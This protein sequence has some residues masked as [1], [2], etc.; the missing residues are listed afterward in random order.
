M[1]GPAKRVLPELTYRL[2]V[3]TF[4]QHGA[5]ELIYLGWALLPRIRHAKRVRRAGTTAER[6]V[7]GLD[8]PT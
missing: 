7:I 2:A 1:L 4:G 6:R 5:A 3:Q 8:Q